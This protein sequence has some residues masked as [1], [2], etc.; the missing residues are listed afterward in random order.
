MTTYSPYARVARFTW[1]PAGALF[2]TFFVV[3]LV[4]LTFE[5]ISVS[6]LARVFG[7]AIRSDVWWFTSWQAVASTAATF[8]VAMPATWV[9]A[10]H[11]FRG[12]RALV[13]LLTLPFLLPTVVVGVAFLAILPSELHYTAIAVILAHA[14]FNVAVFVR[15][16]GPVWAGVPRALLHAAQTLGASPIV[17]FRTVTIPLIHRALLSALGITFLFCFTSYGVVRI[18][19]G[20]RLATVETEIYLRAVGLGDIGLAIALG[21]LQM[22]VLVAVALIVTRF[23]GERMFS[24]ANSMPAAE[25]SGRVGVIATAYAALF[26][27]PIFVVFFR[28]FNVSGSTSW[29]GWR[30]VL[31]GEFGG[32]VL[33]SL[34]YALVAAALTVVVGFGVAH[35]VVQRNVRLLEST[36]ASTLTVSSVTLGLALIVTFDTP[37]FDLRSWWLITPI[38]HAL[39]ALPIVVRTITPVVASISPGLSHAAAT[40]G[41]SPL[42]SWLGI[43]WPLV[44]PAVLAASAMSFAVSIGE[45]GATSLLTRRSSETMPVAIDR[46]LGRPGDL[47]QLGAYAMASILIVVCIVATALLDRRRVGVA[48]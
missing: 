42:R 4:V 38:A 24:F 27:L 43:Q 48:R 28:S 29:S 9:V 1:L 36:S 26:A 34:Q 45:F 33:Q 20:P 21:I 5:G 46:L 15:V 22:A 32:A 39:V 40:L 47:N 35:T 13:A 16:V 31:T 41:A 10:R 30:Q 3:P 11:D 2:I 14:Y 23:A 44:R 12:R 19:G 8:A 17:V 25:K 6:D 18:L 7:D 37:P